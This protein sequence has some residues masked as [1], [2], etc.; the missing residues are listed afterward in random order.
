M[1]LHNDEGTTIHKKNIKDVYA[2][3]C[4]WKYKYYLK[5]TYINIEYWPKESNF[6]KLVH[7]KENLR[8]I[9]KKERDYLG[10]VPFS[11]LSS[12]K[13]DGRDSREPFSS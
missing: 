8:R 3:V 12:T 13:M 4:L 10:L 11:V 6:I 1:V 9:V 2:W 5:L 7:R